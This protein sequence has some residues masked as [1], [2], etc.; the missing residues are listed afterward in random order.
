MILT[1]TLDLLVETKISPEKLKVDVKS[2]V[3]DFERVVKNYTSHVKS[4]VIDFNLLF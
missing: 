4:F 2:F 3:I 1:D